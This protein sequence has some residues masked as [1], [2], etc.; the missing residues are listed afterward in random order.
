MKILIL[1][2]AYGDD[3]VKSARWYA[4]SRGRVQRHPDYLAQATAVLEKEDHYCKMIDGAAKNLSEQDTIVIAKDFRPDITVIQ[5]STP[6]IYSDIH[7]AELCKNITGCITILVGPHVTAEPELTLIKGNGSV[8]IVARG[9]YDYTLRDI[10]QGLVWENIPGI[11]YFKEGK[12][13]HNLARPLIEDVDSLPFPAWQH[14]NPYDYHDAGKLYPFIT[15]MGGRGCDAQCTF[16]VTPSLMY[17]RRY[18]P[19]SAELVVDEMEY[20]LN[21]FPY[22]KEIM[23]E[24]DTLGLK[25]HQPRLRKI[26]E[27][28]LKRGVKVSWSANLRA[29]IRDL[30]LLKLMKRAGCRWVCVGFEFGNQEVLN[31]VRKGTKLDHMVE[32]ATLANKAGLEVNGCFMIGGPGET[33]DT[34]KQTIDL[35]KK[36]PITAAQFTGVVAYPGTAYYQWVKENGFLI[37]KDW[38]EWVDE[39]RE[40]GTVVSFPEL[41]KERIDYYVDKGLKEFYLRP[42]QIIRVARSIKSRSELK[43]KIYGLFS[44]IDYFGKTGP[45]AKV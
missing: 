37:P 34:A 13:S 18:R 21:L 23:I 31:N 22:L 14:I 25:R 9:E 33:E 8:D 43:A 1:N 12:T 38:P 30:D 28:I 2:P 35:A 39:N 27:E 5:T 11:S 6:S 7:Y 3:F 40:Q 17:G 10:A 29:D 32:F 26:C 44:F 42:S 36:L 45:D 19:R 16:C 41:P 20:D 15:L 24:D 4:K